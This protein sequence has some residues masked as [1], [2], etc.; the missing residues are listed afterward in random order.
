MD[1][2]TSV[3][4]Y[5]IYGRIWDNLNQIYKVN[6]IFSDPDFPDPVY[7]GSR[8]NNGFEVWTAWPDS[9]RGYTWGLLGETSRS[10]S[11]R[12]ISSSVVP[13]ELLALHLLV[14]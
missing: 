1:R 10:Y 2:A 6:H 7:W 14:E 4:N 9:K 13:K 3:K 12:P 8:F 5:H 11:W